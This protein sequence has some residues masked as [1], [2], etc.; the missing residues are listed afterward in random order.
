MSAS[1]LLNSTTSSYCAANDTLN[2]S[3]NGPQQ[4]ILTIPFIQMRMLPSSV[5][6]SP[7][8]GALTLYL[9]AFLRAF[10]VSLTHPSS[11]RMEDNTNR[12]IFW[13]C[14]CCQSTSGSWEGSLSRKVSKYILYKT[15][16]TL[17]LLSCLPVLI[18]SLCF[19]YHFPGI[20][21]FFFSFLQST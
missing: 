15:Q 11:P 17:T 3:L 6:L 21:A 18:R 10:P 12:K 5:S 19:L 9:T 14:G 4:I 8:H 2:A 16:I 13:G 7:R 1:K 20:K